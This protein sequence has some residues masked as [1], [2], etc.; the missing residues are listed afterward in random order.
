MGTQ[1]DGARSRIQTKK[2][3][4]NAKYSRAIA[5]AS[6]KL[7]I[8]RNDKKVLTTIAGVDQGDA[9]SG[10]KAGLFERHLGTR[11]FRHVFRTGRR[12]CGGI[13][14]APNSCQE[15]IVVLL[16]GTRYQV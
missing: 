12:A 14:G 16:S 5:A 7:P 4:K 15:K 3:N 2:I 6:L 9:T 10:S 11:V 8:R 1:K 13:G